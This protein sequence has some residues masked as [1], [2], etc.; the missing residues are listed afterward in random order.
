MVRSRSTAVG[1]LGHL[2]G[3]KTTPHIFVIN[4]GGTLIYDRAID[5]RPTTEISDIPAA[6]NY[7][8]AALGAAMASKPVSEPVTRPYGCPVK[9]AH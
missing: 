3:A 8:N 2:Y 7:V 9:Y 4:P 5:D 1:E 6:K